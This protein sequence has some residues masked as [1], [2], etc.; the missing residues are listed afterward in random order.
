MEEGPG[1]L[2]HRFAN[3]NPQHSE[4]VK[5]PWRLSRL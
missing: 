3:D 2:E 1:K 4:I 5:R